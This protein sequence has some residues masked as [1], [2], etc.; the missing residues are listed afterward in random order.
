MG[1]GSVSVCAPAGGVVL[2]LHIVGTWSFGE[3][4]GPGV[5]WQ[6]LAGIPNQSHPATYGKPWEAPL[7]KTPAELQQALLEGTL[8]DEPLSP[9][10]RM[11]NRVLP[12]HAFVAPSSAAPAGVEPGSADSVPFAPTSPAQAAA[13]TPPPRHFP[14]L[15][16][17]MT[18]VEGYMGSYV[19]GYREDSGEAVQHLGDGSV[20]NGAFK[21]GRRNGFGVYRGENRRVFQGKWVRGVA[22]GKGG[23]VG[24]EGVTYEGL[25]S[26]N[27]LA[28]KTGG[29]TSRVLP[30]AALGGSLSLRY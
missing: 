15:P 18:L 4:S 13:P 1:V 23:F 14:E 6:L 10:F 3:L 29:S 16:L 8:R 25:W 27:A 19:G 2:T 26:G 22:E 30:E 7:L 9:G 17:G 12:A 11:G 5:V 20:Y 28:Y 24:A 21:G